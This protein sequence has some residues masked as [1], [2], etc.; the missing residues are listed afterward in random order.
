MLTF[1]TQL[2]GARDKEPTFSLGNANSYGGMPEGLMCPVCEQVTIKGCW[3]QEDETQGVF[4][5]D[6]SSTKVKVSQGQRLRVCI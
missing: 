5:M 6:C 1:A 2:E 4:F 3:Y